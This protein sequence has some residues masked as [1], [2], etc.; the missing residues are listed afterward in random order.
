MKIK[1][2]GGEFGLIER[3]KSKIKLYS[4]DI[5]AGIGDDAAV[6]KHDKNNYILFTTD[7]LVENDHFSLKYSK[8]EQIGM[9]AIEQNVSD[10]AAMGGLP[11]HA[12]ISLA[13]PN[14]ID[15]EFVDRLYDGMNKK[16][17]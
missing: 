7:M 12:V 11:R 13:L 4:K 3:I 2:I 9:K 16:A 8:P 10:I 6:L 1:Q 17:S 14:K 15:A 5:V